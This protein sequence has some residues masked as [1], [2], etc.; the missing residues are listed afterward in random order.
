MTTIQ[1]AAADDSHQTLTI[2]LFGVLAVLAVVVTYEVVRRWRTRLEQR[3]VS[4]E[5][6]G[7]TGATA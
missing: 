5:L 3:A 7:T 4:R 2:V 1:L 6:T